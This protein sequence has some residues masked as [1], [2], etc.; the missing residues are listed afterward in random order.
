MNGLLPQPGGFEGFGLLVGEI[1]LR[2]CHQQVIVECPDGPK[3]QIQVDAAPDS[4]SLG[5][6]A[7]KNLVA[8][9]PEIKGFDPLLLEGVRFHP[10]PPGGMNS[11]SGWALSTAASKSPRLKA[12]WLRRSASIIAASRSSIARAVSRAEPLGYQAGEKR[13]ACN[14]Q[15]PSGGKGRTE[16]EGHHISLKAAAPS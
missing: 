6:L 11:I 13:P 9:D 5:V 8:L 15:Q 14:V 16:P 10:R 7:D 3:L 1:G 2:P 12:S 4:P